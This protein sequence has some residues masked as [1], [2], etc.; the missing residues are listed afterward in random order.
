MR[1]FLGVPILVRGQAFGNL[2]LTEKEGG[3]FDQADEDAIVVLADW[4]A[5]AIENARWAAERERLRNSIEASEQERRRW[6]RE[7]HDETLQGLGGL[8]MLLSSALRGADPERLRTVRPRGRSADRHRDREPAVADRRAASARARRDRARPGDRDP[9]PA[10]GDQRGHDRRDE[11]RALTRGRRTAS[12]R[13]REHGL[14]A[15]AGSP[16]ECREAR[17]RRPTRGRAAETG[18][19][20]DGHGPRRRT[21][22]RPGRPDDGVRASSGC[23]SA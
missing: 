11:H 21:R 17:G 15:R 14:P 7:L 8:Q 16:H 23:A 5:I 4:A 9:R 12:P 20:R 3:E 2:Y 19:R 10:N 1:T 22:L 6:A 13:R 18:R